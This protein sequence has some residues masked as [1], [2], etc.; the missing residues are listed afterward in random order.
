MN[1][2]YLTLMELEEYVNPYTNEPEI[3][4]NQWHYRWVTEDGEEFYTDSE[5]H[6][7]NIASVLNR[8]DWR[9]TAI[10]PRLPQEG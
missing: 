3:G 10:R 1:D 8:T 5:E 4:S 2:N 6:D 7:P 9:R